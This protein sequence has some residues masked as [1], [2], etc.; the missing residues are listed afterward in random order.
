MGARCCSA[1][2]ECRSERDSKVP[3]LVQVVLC[4]GDRDQTSKLS[5]MQYPYRKE[6]GR[7]GARSFRWGRSEPFLTRCRWSRDPKAVSLDFT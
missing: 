5:V 3:V 7:P 6:Q 1:C 2:W 4:W